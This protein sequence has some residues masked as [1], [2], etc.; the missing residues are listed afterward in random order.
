GGSLKVH[1]NSSVAGAFTMAS[2]T[3]LTSDGAGSSFTTT[4]AAQINNVNLY[5]TAGGTLSLPGITTFPQTTANVTWRAFGAGSVLSLPD[6]GSITAGRS[7][8]IEAVS[9]GQ[10][11]LPKVEQVTVLGD[12]NT[13]I[14]ADGVNSQI[15][16][17]WIWTRWPQTGESPATPTSSSGSG[18]RPP[19]RPTLCTWT[20]CE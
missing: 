14:R 17:S 9:E 20:T 13:T 2:G 1:A 12:A 8:S 3:T 16:S 6:L 7:M 5:A 18:M 15:A 10:V 11:S 19:I 4:G